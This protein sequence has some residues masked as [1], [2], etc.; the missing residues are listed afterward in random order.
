MLFCSF[1]DIRIKRKIV[2]TGNPERGTFET[3]YNNKQQKYFQK[4]S[5]KNSE[6]TTSSNFN[7][8]IGLLL[9]INNKLNQVD[10]LLLSNQSMLVLNNAKINQLLHL[11]S[12]K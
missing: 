2:F 1:L 5:M 4:S 11:I 7:S 9:A 3:K 12:K 8:R 10:E 6:I